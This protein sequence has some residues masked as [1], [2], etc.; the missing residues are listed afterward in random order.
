MQSEVLNTS[1]ARARFVGAWPEVLKPW[2]VPKAAARIHG[3][4]LSENG[5]LEAATIQETLGISAGSTSS[6][7]RFLV[8]I[9]LV[10]RMKI[11][12][13]RKARYG[14]TSDPARIFTALADARRNQAFKAIQT[15]G[16][17][18][19]SIADKQ[20][21]HWLNTLW[22]LRTLSD[23]LDRWLEMCSKRDPEWTIKQL[24]RL[25]KKGTLEPF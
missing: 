25:S 21:L 7:L 8:R 23:S 14:A 3:L 4:L 10:E 13:A 11:L 16:P 1:P 17:S 12:K 24:D 22:Q 20:D 19:T 9:G 6:Q 2:G 15:L 18:I 5:T